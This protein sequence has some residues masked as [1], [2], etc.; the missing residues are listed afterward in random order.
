MPTA[1]AKVWRWDQAGMSPSP[2]RRAKLEAGSRV[3]EALTLSQLE[4]P[5]NRAKDKVSRTK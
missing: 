1:L 2:K 3:K 5:R 4:S